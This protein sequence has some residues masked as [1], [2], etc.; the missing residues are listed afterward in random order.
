MRWWTQYGAEVERDFT[1][2]RWTAHPDITG[3]KQFEGVD[4]P[5]LCLRPGRVHLGGNSGYQ[6]VN[7]VFHEGAAEIILLGYD[8]QRGPNGET[9]HHGQHDGGLPNLKAD[10]GDWAQRFIQLGIDLRAQGVRVINATRRTAIGCFERRSIEDALHIDRPAAVF[11]A[12]VALQGAALLVPSDLLPAE[13][14]ALHSGLGGCGYQVSNTNEPTTLSVVWGGRTK[15][16]K[17]ARFIVAENGYLRDAQGGPYVAL[18]LG[19]HNGAGQPAR[20]APERWRRL[21]VDVK[22]WRKTGDHILL[23]PSRGLPTGSEPQPDGWIEATIAELRRSSDRKVRV[24]WH[25]GNW[26]VNAPAVPIEDDLRNAWA[27]VI[28]NSVAG[29]KALIEGVPVIYTAKDWIC[30]SAAGRRLGDIEW[31][32]TP[33]RTEA[34]ERLAGSQW[35]LP[36]IASGEALR[37][38]LGELTVLCVLKTGGDYTPE[39]VRKLRDG[40]AKH[41]TIPHRFVC[42]SDVDVPCERIPLVHGWR[43]WWSKIEMFRPGVI[44]G[45]TLYL[46]LDTVIVNKLDAVATIPFEFAML[47]IRQKIDT[48]VGNSGA[49]WFT[50]PFPHVYERFAERPEY[51]IDY[52]TQHARDRYMG[53]QAFISDSFDN[54]PKLHE[55]L[56]GFFQSYKFDQC[57]QS[58]P[59]ECAVVCFGGHP[60]PHEAGGWVKQV[61]I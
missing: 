33:D 30:A 56:P 17:G 24:R 27:C 54:L 21:G 51:W 25:P 48:T 47:N 35:T 49:M 58:V 1:G 14:A 31:P 38:V 20:R 16:P 7:A 42:L 4:G 23:C 45:P 9:H 15:D 40:V 57:Q 8:M 39:Y 55:A 61:W 3:A 22:P 44:T 2:E 10:L 18:G 29:V 12:S 6:L 26:K 37:N 32:Q 34:L 19:G 36:E 53:D 43:G 41:L 28:W 50:R 60:R 59:P 52:H 11:K 46:D 5:G 13:H